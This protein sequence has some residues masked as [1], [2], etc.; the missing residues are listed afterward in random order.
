MMLCI[1]GNSLQSIK[2][3]H[4]I[5][6]KNM[7]R[8]N[9][10]RSFIVCVVLFITNILSMEKCERDDTYKKAIVIG[11]TSGIGEALVKELG[12]RNYVVGFTGRREN[13]LQKIQQECENETYIAH[14]DVSNIEESKETL[15]SLIYQM[16]GVDVFIY[17]AGVCKF[18]LD[19]ETQEEII[20]VNVKGFVSQVHCVTDYFLK[21]GGGHIVT[22]SSVVSSRGLPIAPAYSG[23]KAFMT[24]YC[25]GL[26]E[27]FAHLKNNIS[28]T[29]I[30]PGLVDTEMGKGSNFC[31]ASPKDVASQ[32]LDVIERKNKHA[33]VPKIW[34]LLALLSQ[35]LPDCCFY[36]LFWRDKEMNN[37]LEK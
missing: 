34:G 26:G 30:E 12:K 36:G 31:K 20:D 11:G 2:I 14:M 25:Q 3:I 7:A 17:N 8:F 13:L 32:I 24:N 19:W 9:R 29:T 5:K 22:I 1:L 21:N 10:M 16:K 4:I 15:N 18:K 23:S 35:L 6:D 27:R 33:Y 28:V 37:L